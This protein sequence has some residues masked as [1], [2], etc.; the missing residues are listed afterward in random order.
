[1]IPSKSAALA[2][3][4]Q[5]RNLRPFED[6]CAWIRQ[7]RNMARRCVVLHGFLASPTSMQVPCAP[8]T[9]AALGTIPRISSRQHEGV[10]A[11][12]FH[13]TTYPAP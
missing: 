11:L 13:P 7:T 10:E 6:A 5:H 4:H 1:M 2:L 12:E 8:E 3:H 9:A